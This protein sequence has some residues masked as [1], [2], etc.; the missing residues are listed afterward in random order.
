MAIKEKEGNGVEVFEQNQNPPQLVFNARALATTFSLAVKGFPSKDDYVWA[1]PRKVASQ[2]GW[3]ES[4]LKTALE[5][6]GGVSGIFPI[7]PSI[8]Q[9]SRVPWK[10]SSH[11][12]RE[13]EDRSEPACSSTD[14]RGTGWGRGPW[15]L[16]GLVSV[17]LISPRGSRGQRESDIPHCSLA[18][19]CL[20]WPAC[21]HLGT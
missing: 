10:G 6:W 1:K 21:C 11:W 7:G 12:R 13:P 16:V 17:T 14:R 9:P 19:F 20:S 18:V 3:G 4:R 2:S 5:G 8:P 15:I